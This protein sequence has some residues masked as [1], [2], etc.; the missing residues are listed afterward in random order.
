MTGTATLRR[1]AAGIAGPPV[2]WSAHFVFVYVFNALACLWGWGDI[3]ALGVGLI[4][5]VVAVATLVVGALIA[6][7]GV[8]AWRDRSALAADDGPA[9]RPI[10]VA[11]VGA[12]VSALF[13][14]ATLLVGLPTLMAP[15]CY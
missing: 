6:L 3:S 11:R 13:L 4:E 14:F 1:P 5:W 15:S 10:F 12:L 7:L 9:P 8:Q 2:L